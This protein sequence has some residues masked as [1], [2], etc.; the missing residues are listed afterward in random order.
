MLSITLLYVRLLSGSRQYKKTKRHFV[1]GPPTFNYRGTVFPNCL[2]HLLIEGYQTGATDSAG[3]VHIFISVTLSIIINRR[4]RRR[5]EHSTRTHATQTICRLIA[6]LNWLRKWRWLLRGRNREKTKNNVSNLT[7]PP[8][9][10]LLSAPSIVVWGQK[11]I[12]RVPNQPT[13][14][15]I[16]VA[17]I[18]WFCVDSDPSRYHSSWSIITHAIS[19]IDS[20]SHDIALSVQ[21]S[22]WRNRPH[23]SDAKSRYSKWYKIT[24]WAPNE[25]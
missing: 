10:P 11:A 6:K 19:P 16:S 25:R 2:K 21:E 1:H 23:Y 8:R 7:H 9:L 22:L 20:T 17:M 13:Q 3:C 15:R 18:N 5:A 4:R 12:I 24:F 14:R